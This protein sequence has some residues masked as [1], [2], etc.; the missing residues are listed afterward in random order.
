MKGAE[1]KAVRKSASPGLVAAFVAILLYALLVWLTARP[2]AAWYAVGSGDEEGLAKAAGYDGGNSL[3]PYLLGK[4][5][6]LNIGSPDPA[7]AIAYYR[8]A[9]ALNPLQAGAW[10]ALS[11]AMLYSGRRAEAEYALDRAILLNPSDANL[12]WEASTFWLMIGKVDKAVTSMRKFIL[13]DPGGQRPVYDLCWKLG[14]GNDII[15]QNL[16]PRQY[17]YEKRYLEY[18]IT[19]GRTAATEAVWR[20]I[21]K[22]RVGRNI[23]IR[24]INFL[25]DAGHYEEADQNWKEVAMKSAGLKSGDYPPL[26]WNGDFEN[27]ILNG[28]FGWTV[29]RAD[30]VD[31]FID[32]SVHVTGNHSLGVSFTGRNPDIT[33]AKQVVR[34]RPGGKYRLQ[35]YVKT[36]SLT[37]TSGIFL[38]VEGLHCSGLS[39]RSDVISG[40]NF[41]REVKV[42]FQVPQDCLAAVIK[43]RRARSHKLDNKITG[44]AWIDSLSLRE[45]AGTL[46][47]GSERP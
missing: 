20:L 19:S 4:Y 41:W 30:G 7:R 44:T 16:L 22:N 28:G 24:Y 31:L 2:V 1:R 43:I 39:G 10:I 23:S 14:L 42:D 46:M 26:I 27:E 17:R 47:A 25:I 13:L 34:V 29:G 36:E 35:A 8:R 3:Y 11:R 5:Y 15:I 21:D 12:M 9:L 40:T 38:A 45:Q 33:I 32:D 18:L 6:S 37:T